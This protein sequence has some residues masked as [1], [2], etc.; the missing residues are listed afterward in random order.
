MTEREL[1]ETYFDLIS[2][3]NS[4]F[5]FWLSATFAITMAFHFT[6]TQISKLLKRYLLT[7]YI[8]TSLIF[9]SRFTNTGLSLTGIYRKLLESGSS[10]ELGIAVPSFVIGPTMIVIMMAGTIGAVYYVNKVSNGSV[11]ND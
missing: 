4:D 2:S 9:I 10:L 3:S 5:E 1:I 11:N 7:L 6:G 8:F